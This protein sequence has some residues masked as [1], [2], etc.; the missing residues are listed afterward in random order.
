M[1]VEVLFSREDIRKTYEELSWHRRSKDIIQEYALNMR[2]IR[3]VALEGVDLRASSDVLDLGCGYGFFTESLAGRLRPGA[4]VM[5]IDVVDHSNRE[6]FL[7]TVTLMGYRASFIHGSAD[8]IRDMA[9]A[10]FDLVIASYSL[11]FFPHLIPDIARVLRRGGLFIAVTHSKYSLRELTSFVPFSM[12]TAGLGQPGELRINRLFRAFSM[13]DGRSQLE[14][15]FDDVERVVYENSLVFPLDRFEAC[16]DYLDTKK[17]LILKEVTDT[18][19]ARFD[20]VY[21]LL[22]KALFDHASAHGKVLIT[23]D[24]GIFRCRLPVHGG[25]IA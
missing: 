6:S 17:H 8:I 12:R 20:T 15:Y 19:P 5:G 1:G 23:K 3:E 25:R 24:D 14:S 11:Y 2:D 18:H 21:A 22:V 4:K 13:E 10:G 16:I 7:D 9:H